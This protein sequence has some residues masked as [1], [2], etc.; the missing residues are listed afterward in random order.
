MLMG[1]LLGGKQYPLYDYVVA[2]TIG[3]G[4]TLMIY[5]EM[6][7]LCPHARAVIAARKLYVAA[8]LHGWIAVSWCCSNT[9]CDTDTARTHIQLH[10]FLLYTSKYLLV[11]LLRRRNRAHVILAYVRVLVTRMFLLGVALFVTSSEGLR[12]GADSFGQQGAIGCGL[13]LLGLYLLFDSFTSQVSER[14]HAAYIW[15]LKLSH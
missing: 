14:A 12:L 11:L 3:L 13:L 9:R 15:C 10:V 4:K 8:L 7:N 1:K 2:G 5:H 6:C